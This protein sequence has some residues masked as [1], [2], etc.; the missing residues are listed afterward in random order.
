MTAAADEPGRR[1]EGQEAA[2]KPGHRRHRHP[3]R[4]EVRM[5]LLKGAGIG[6]TPHHSLL[7][8]AP[9][10][11]SLNKVPVGRSGQAA[12]VSSIRPNRRA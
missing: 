10:T 3:H 2:V 8:R 4:T 7:G 6:G 1:S 9:E 12:R 11:G 5:A